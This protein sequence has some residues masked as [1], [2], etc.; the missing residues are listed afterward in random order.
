MTNWRALREYRRIKRNR[1]RIDNIGSALLG[2]GFLG[3][4]VISGDNSTLT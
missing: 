1:R 4:V 3:I 2:I